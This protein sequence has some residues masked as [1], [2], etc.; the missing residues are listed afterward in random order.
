MNACGEKVG[1]DPGSADHP[2]SNPFATRWVRPGA[3]PFRFARSESM[4][5]IVARLQNN[6]WRGAIIG[7]HGTGKST[8]V[9]SLL[10][11][12]ADAGKQPVFF[13]FVGNALCGARNVT[14][15]NS[16]CDGPTFSEGNS[17]GGVPNGSFNQH[18]NTGD[19]LPLDSLFTRLPSAKTNPA[20]LVTTTIVVID[21]YEQLSLL[22]RLR[23][24]WHCRRTGCGLL[25]T[26][27]RRTR[28][29]SVYHTHPDEAL[30]CEL[31][32]EALPSHAGLIGTEEII[33]AFQRRHQN[34]RETFFDLYDL[35]E[36]R[37]LG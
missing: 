18:A 26:A 6:R 5:T 11:T 25:V 30:V 19:R 24:H 37:R 28:L 17:L 14:L 9:Q 16:G 34:V 10:P 2:P 21:G 8:L 3:I 4:E 27:H 22:N 1:S 31:V 32:R 20:P 13:R 36:S 23:L 15:Q 29:P 7:P 12:L 33:A 35:F